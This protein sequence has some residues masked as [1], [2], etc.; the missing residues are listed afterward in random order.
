MST[1]RV[2]VPPGAVSGGTV[3]IDGGTL[4]HLRTVLRLRVGEE[5]VVTDGTG[6]EFLARLTRL[7]RGGGEAA[8]LERREPRRES[9]LRTT[10]AQA[11]PKGDRFELALEKAV[12]LG[13]NEVVPL[14]SR[15]TLPAARGA[16]GTARLERWR[17]VA[18]G[19]VAQSGRTLS[20]EVPAPRAF[21]EFVAD[22]GDAEVRLLLWER[23]GA[24]LGEVVAQ[25]PRPGSLLVAAGPEG[26]WEEDEVALAL[27]SGF[28]AVRLGPRT[29]RSETAGL[30][31]LAI[32]QH[33]WGDV[34]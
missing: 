12:E 29:L 31:A 1:P 34:G 10:L 4:G 18:E 2:F 11:V 15:R 20:P 25:L 9:P 26:S 8:V 3:A 22:P 13:V 14:L 27:S 5:L 23:A 6:V 32:L 17:R 16:A 21:E 28:R 19:A 7:G 30:V 24:G 33:R